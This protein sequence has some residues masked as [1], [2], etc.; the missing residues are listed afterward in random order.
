MIVLDT[1]IISET[2]K[3]SP[4]PSVI[5][6]IDDYLE[7][8]VYIPALVLGEI[9][10][11]VQSLPDGTKRQTLCIWLDQL[12]DRFRGRIL[13]L[14]QPVCVLWGSLSARLQKRGE[15]LPAIDLLL[16]ALATHHSAVFATRN[17][18]RFAPTGIDLVNPWQ[19]PA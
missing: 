14:D 8:Q 1:C 7:T 2:L 11:G 12:E 18:S 3:P 16:A 9:H 15:N 17:T 19:H 13:S 10:K 5:A 4:S 6:W